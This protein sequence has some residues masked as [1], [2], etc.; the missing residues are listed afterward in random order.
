MLLMNFNF[1]LFVSRV[2]IAR[3]VCRYLKYYVVC[4][5]CYIILP[6]FALKSFLH[7]RPD[8]FNWTFIY[9]SEKNLV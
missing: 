8:T 4:V 6:V 5:E 7:L 9:Y 1:F 2:P 3:K